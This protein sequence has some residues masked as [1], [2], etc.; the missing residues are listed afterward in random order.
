[1]DFKKNGWEYYWELG[2]CKSV[3]CIF[4]QCIDKGTLLRESNSFLKTVRKETI[5]EH[6]REYNESGN[7]E[8]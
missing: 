6:H 2:Y 7:N 5:K 4:C 1:M 3:E 8:E